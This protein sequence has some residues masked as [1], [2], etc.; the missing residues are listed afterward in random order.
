MATLYKR[1]KQWVSRISKWNGIKK[2]IT[3]IPLRTENKIVARTRH[4][5]GEKLESNFPYTNT[6]S[7][8]TTT[9]PF[10]DNITPRELINIFILFV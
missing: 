3:D 5:K 2:I 9:P 8:N 1:R 7:S 10:N 4:Q 6:H